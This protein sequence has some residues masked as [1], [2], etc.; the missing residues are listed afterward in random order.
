MTTKDKPI[1]FTD[2]IRMELPNE[3]LEHLIDCASEAAYYYIKANNA[4]EQLIDLVGFIVIL[5]KFWVSKIE[6]NLTPGQG[7][8]ML[9]MIP[10][11]TECIYS[12]GG[13]LNC[14]A[15]DMQRDPVK[16]KK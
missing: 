13:E 9:E 8:S 2:S 10:E 15:G 1:D 4:P 14:E 11:I 5:A 12:L 7:K 6:K 3:F 16:W